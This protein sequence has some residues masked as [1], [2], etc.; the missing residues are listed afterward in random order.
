[1]IL[2]ICAF[3]NGTIGAEMRSTGLAFAKNLY[4]IE[5]KKYILKD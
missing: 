1:M 3:G 2:T 4:S 5:Y